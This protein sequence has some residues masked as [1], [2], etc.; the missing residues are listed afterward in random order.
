MKNAH[1]PA[2]DSDIDKFVILFPFFKN[3]VATYAD[4]FNINLKYDFDA[5]AI[6]K[7]VAAAILL[8]PNFTVISGTGIQLVPETSLLVDTK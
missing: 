5:S 1:A 2:L 7:I 3:Q 6:S 4:P 8:T